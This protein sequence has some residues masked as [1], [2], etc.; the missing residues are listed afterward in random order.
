MLNS[1][2]IDY[3]N[4][5]T[6]MVAVLP[7]DKALDSFQPVVKIALIK[8]KNTVGKMS[9]TFCAHAFRIFVYFKTLNHYIIPK[10]SKQC[11]HESLKAKMALQ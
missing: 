4:L 11:Y 10:K 2:P 7:T 1:Y 6:M 3:S 9:A 8:Y 5:T